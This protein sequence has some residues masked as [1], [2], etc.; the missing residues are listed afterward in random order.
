[1]ATSV[2]GTK[3]N[4]GPGSYDGKRA[5]GLFDKMPS[6][7]FRS[8]SQQRKKG[9]GEDTPGVG[10]YK[11]RK[12]AVEPNQ[13]NTGHGMRAKSERFRPEKVMT[14]DNVGPGLYDFGEFMST[15]LERSISKMSRSG[16]GFGT[17]AVQRELPYGAAALGHPGPGSYD[18]QAIV[19]GVDPNK[20]PSS[21]FKSGSK[22]MDIEDETI[23]DPGSYDPYEATDLAQEA[24]R[25]FQR[26]SRSGEASFGTKQAREMDQQ[27]VGR[28]NPGPGSYRA[29]KAQEEFQKAMP[30]SAFRSSS[31]QRK[32][33]FRE[34]T[35]GVGTYKPR[36]ES[37]EPNTGN[38][39][40]GMVG[41][42]ERFRPEKTMTDDNVGPGL[43]DAATGEN[44]ANRS[45]ADAAKFGSSCVFSS[46][47]VR[48]LPY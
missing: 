43:Y 40:H 21:A 4:P 1:M 2:V 15:E 35:P 6:S 28:E 41:K 22:R 47:T 45:Q 30:S 34:D 42:S 31:Q 9:P 32:H 36:K 24:S 29:K 26:S 20:R 10:T 11:P 17:K 33:G 3:E 16:A 44:I 7:A 14:D 8:T 18:E 48:G 23:G 27:L 38:R 19:A 12:E 37:V 5:E 39:A 46:D 25:T 13:R